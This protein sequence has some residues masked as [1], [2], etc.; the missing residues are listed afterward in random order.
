MRRTVKPSCAGPRTLAAPAD[1]ALWPKD[2]P[3]DPD[4]RAD[5]PVKA[6][7]EMRAAAVDPDQRDLAIRVLLHDLVRDPHE[8]TP[9]VVLVEDDLGVRHAASFLASRD[10]VKGVDSSAP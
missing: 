10:R 9:D 8:R 4:A 7:G 1:G 3:R 2:F 6:R 5:E